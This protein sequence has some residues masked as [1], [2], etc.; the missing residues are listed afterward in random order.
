MELTKEE[1]IRLESLR[2]ALSLNPPMLVASDLIDSA[3]TIANFIVNT[4]SDCG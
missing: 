2:L 4:T 1:Q 3:K